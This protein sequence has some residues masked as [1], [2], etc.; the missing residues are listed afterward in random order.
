MSRRTGE[1]IVA[2]SRQEIGKKRKKEREEEKKK[3][4]GVSAD[5]I[6]KKNIKSKS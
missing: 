5:Q 3:E 6:L 4:Q 2:C 1:Q